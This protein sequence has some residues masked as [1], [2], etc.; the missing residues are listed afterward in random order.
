MLS[1]VRVGALAALVFLLSA[2][3]STATLSTA[4]A[5]TA[6]TQKAFQRDEL[7]DAA[8]KLEAQIRSEAG[9]VTRSVA[10]LR[11]EADAALQRNNPSGG[12]RLLGQIT[13][14]APDD[15]ANWLR[16]AQTTLQVRPANVRERTTQLERAA[17]AAYIA[18]QRSKSPTEEAASL[19]I[20]SRSYADRQLWRPALP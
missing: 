8:I 17:A 7:A 9:Q 13:V 19:L 16:L 15:S 1:S 11:R 5:A 3:L 6:V 20:V 18:Y 14:I 2:A 10:V 4:M 12:L